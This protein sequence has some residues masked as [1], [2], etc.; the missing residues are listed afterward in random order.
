MCKIKVVL[1]AERTCPP[2]IPTASTRQTAMPDAADAEDRAFGHKIH[3]VLQVPSAY[4][5]SRPESRGAPNTKLMKYGLSSRPSLRQA[6]TSCTIWVGLK[7]SHSGLMPRAFIVSA[8]STACGGLLIRISLPSKTGT[9]CWVERAHLGA[10][11]DA[12]EAF[13]PDG[14]LMAVR[15]LTHHVAVDAAAR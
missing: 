14:L 10:R 2:R 8:S 6:V 11:L 3:H 4:T 1:E 9:G 12:L 5:A 7:T 13:L 15:H